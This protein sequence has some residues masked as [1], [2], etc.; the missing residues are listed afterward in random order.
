MAIRDQNTDDRTGTLKQLN[1]PPP[2]LST[3]I[4][5]KTSHL[6]A[7]QGGSL[8]SCLLKPLTWVMQHKLII[9]VLLSMERKM[10]RFFTTYQ[11]LL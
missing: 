1:H 9:L 4:S 6:L 2:H 5:G 7:D 3:V 11:G 10:A 8:R